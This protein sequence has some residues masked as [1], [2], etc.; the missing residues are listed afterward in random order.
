MRLKYDLGTVV[1]F[2]GWVLQHG[3][4]CLGNQACIIYHM[5][6]SV[7]ERLGIK[8]PSWVNKVLYSMNLA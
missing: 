1:A 4:N 3:M 6:E 2:M 5:K 7:V 8:K